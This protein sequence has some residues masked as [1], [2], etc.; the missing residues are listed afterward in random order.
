VP[1]NW[2]DSRIR[3]ANLHR[4]PA[5]PT[6]LEWSDLQFFVAVCERG[7]VGAAAKALG[8]NHSTV[9]RRI[10]NLERT[11]AVRLF[12]RLPSGYALTEQGR[13]LE[14][15]VAGVQDQLDAAQR[16]IT[17]SDLALGGTIR[18]TAPDTLSQAFL[19]PLL[20][21]FQA[22]HPAVH[23]ELVAGNNFLNLTQREADVAVR[24]SNHPPEN[25]VGRRAGV[26][27]TALYGSSDYLK[28]LGRKHTKA[29]YR[30]VGHDPALSHL[31]SA[32]WMAKHVAPERVVF[33]VDSLVSMAHAVAAG[34]GV[35][36]LLC[37]LGD[38]RE[39][40]KRIEAPRADFDTQVWVLTHPDLKRVARI[41]A[42]TD[43]LYERLS[44]D[45]RLAPG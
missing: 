14:A 2:Q 16:Q 40:L 34:F 27:Q 4:R 13:A 28:A 5:I 11:L 38:A 25:L 19:V 31:L 32:K 33:R 39:E 44:S 30:W 24:G 8:V 17:G 21:E 20:A 10:A 9:L 6:P 7:S 12:D 42:L 43:F 29:D 3:Y 1:E 35:G 15:G 36:W 26:I 23:L 22:A 37:P 41:K 18:L 45:G